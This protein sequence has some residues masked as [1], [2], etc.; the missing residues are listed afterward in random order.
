MNKKVNL[1]LDSGAYSAFTKGAE[2]VLDDYIA[3]IKENE[4]VIEVYSNLDIM[5]DAEGSLKNQKLMEEAGLTP[6]P[7]YHAGEDLKYLRLYLENYPYVCLGGLTTKDGALLA[8]SLDRCWD[9]ICDT[10]D[11]M[12]KAKIHGFGITALPL[13]F[14]YPWYS[15]DSTSWVMTSRFGGVFVPRKR[16]GKYVYDENSWKVCV[17]NRSPSKSDE[18]KHFTTFTTLEQEIILEYFELKGFSVGHSEF[19]EEVAGYS[20]KD[21]ERWFG[22]ADSDAQ[23][24]VKGNRDGYVPL[25][26]EGEIKRT[27]KGL[28]ETVIEWG[29][30]NDYRLRDELNVIYFLDLEKNIPEWPWAYK[31]KR[32][33]GFGL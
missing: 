4:S 24:G 23:R 17:S 18:G 3:F 8:D 15:V 11:R 9:I 5:Y 31:P 22:K 2:I 10:P 1:F 16:N 29:L 6:L 7:C 21:G 32:M 30:S 12:P 33:R 14:R 19:K 20:L 27:G 13:L 28:V 26:W 25:G